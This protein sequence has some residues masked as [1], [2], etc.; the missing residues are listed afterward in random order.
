MA[1]FRKR[2]LHQWQA[3]IRK[4][5]YPLQSKTFET[6]A[7][8]ARWARAIECEMDRGLFVSRVEAESITLGE[9]L[10]RYVEEV[11]PLKKGAAPEAARIRALI[12]HPLANRFLA[13]LR[14]V[15]LARY[16]DARLKKVSPGTVK[17]ELVILSHL[18]EVAR[19]EWGIHVH[20]PVRDIKLPPNPK[21]RDRRL[22]PGYNGGEDEESQLLRACANARNPFLLPVVRLAIE[23]AMRQ[24]E[25][26]RIRWEHV[27]LNRRTVYLPDTKN[28]DARTAPLSTTAIRVLRTLPRG[29]HGQV[30]PGLTSEAIK[31]AFMRAVRR[32]GI[33]DLRF[34]DTRHEATTR[35]F[36]RGLNIM[37]VASVPPAICGVLRSS[38]CP[39]EF[40]ASPAPGVFNRGDTSTAR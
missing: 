5:G 24:G 4:Q 3:Q 32:A 30:F 18:F 17:R 7:A 21:A 22:Q 39:L 34:H 28:G 29:L 19:K 20:N 33:K 38:E 10:E 1:S 2:G 16:R 35:F 31:R 6:R 37:E 36:E 9:L 13:G 12:K 15:D 40:G 25:L 14:G 8:A 23:T 11:T 27:D 26:V